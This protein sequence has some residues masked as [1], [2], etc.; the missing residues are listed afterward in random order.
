LFFGS[1][2][3]PSI[4]PFIVSPKSPLC[5]SDI[6]IVGRSMAPGCKSKGDDGR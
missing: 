5:C 1:A 2:H 4:L 3:F 6:I